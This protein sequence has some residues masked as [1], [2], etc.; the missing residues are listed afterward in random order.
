MPSL[1][2]PTRCI[3]DE[4]PPRHP[5]PPPL[6]TVARPISREIIE[7]DEY[8]GRTEAAEIVELRARVGGVLESVH[9]V[10]GALVKKDDLLFTIDARQYQATLSRALAELERAR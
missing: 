10:D 8:T 2:S 1:D 4:S 9:F 7:W 5:P 6:V 3:H